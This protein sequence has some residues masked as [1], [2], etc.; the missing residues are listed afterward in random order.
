M[1]NLNVLIVGFR[2]VSVLN[3]GMF[4]LFYCFVI[5]IFVKHELLFS[6]VSYILVAGSLLTFVLGRSPDSGGKQTLNKP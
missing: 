6:S 4:S 2:L 1:C 3:E 5:I